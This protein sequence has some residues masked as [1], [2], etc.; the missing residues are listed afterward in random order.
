MT[1]QYD[2]NEKVWLYPGKAGW[3][4]VT[5]PVDVAKDIDFYFVQEKKGWG[6]L[7]VKVNIGKTHWMT[8]IFPDKK[9][10][11][12]L[13]PLKAEIRKKEQIKEND[14]V[15]LSIELTS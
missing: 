6:S 3:F 15:K 1:R 5:L 7:R 14:V 10:E 2:L 8:S 4:F 11:S 9:S 13:L 12:Y